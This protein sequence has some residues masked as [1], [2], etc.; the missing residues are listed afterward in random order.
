[1]ARNSKSQ[2]GSNQRGSYESCTQIK[3]VPTLNAVL[4][5]FLTAI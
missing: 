5:V 4:G 1:M 3:H 2:V